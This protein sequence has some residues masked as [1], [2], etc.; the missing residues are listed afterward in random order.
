[1][2]RLRRPPLPRSSSS[3]GVDPG[4]GKNSG[5]TV[6]D[7][8]DALI[9]TDDR[10]RV[11]DGALAGV[12]LAV[13]DLVQVH[14]QPTS[15]GAAFDRWPPASA[16]A[17]VV[18]A[19]RNAG[20]TVIGRARLHE[21]AC[22]VTGIN[23]SQGTVANPAAP[24]RVPGGSSSGSAAAVAAGLADLAIGTDTGGSVR[25]P[26]ACCG[27]VGYKPP[28]GVLSLD[29]VVPCAPTLD[30][31][32]LHAPSVALV[33]G[34]MTVLAGDQSPRLPVRL[35]VAEAELADAEAEVAEPVGAVID[36]L[37]IDRVAVTLPAPELVATATTTVLF[38]E[39]TEVNADLTAAQRGLLG[40]DIQ[41]RLSAG[42][43]IDDDAYRE[44]LGRLDEI[45][46]AVDAVLDE[47]DVIVLPT[48]PGVPPT[49][50]AAEAAPVPTA[51][52]LVRFTRLA[53]ATGHAALTVPVPAPLP[54]GLQI[55]G[56]PEAVLGLAA[57]V[58]RVGE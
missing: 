44:A 51:Q 2:V 19:L 43:A 12:R 18:A 14:G 31:V 38:R 15:A 30:H 17:P 16:D 23:G 1:M 41:G 52:A 8:A 20:A 56:R 7:V 13:K 47:V 57:E 6:P 34:A 3:D 32:G 25:I 46:R 45:R 4:G 58:E 9:W 40:A 39:F 5:T 42:E 29:G 55:V 11:A 48:L 36:R 21:L 49:L 10:P 35:G 33:V 53:N 27:V 54:V 26:S 28:R 37:D 22:G 50:E 24:G